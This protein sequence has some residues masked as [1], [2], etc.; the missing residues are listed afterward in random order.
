MATS[1]SL[2]IGYYSGY[3]SR[4]S[5]DEFFTFMKKA[6]MDYVEMGY[7]ERWLSIRWGDVDIDGQHKIK[8]FCDIYKTPY[9]ENMYSPIRYNDDSISISCSGGG[10]SRKWK[11]IVA[12][13]LCAHVVWEC[14]LLGIPVNLI[15]S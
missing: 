13:A 5:S 8:D 10:D 1:F 4:I 6:L 11:E 12:L 7:L 14:S 3:T 9:P 2:Q 15:V